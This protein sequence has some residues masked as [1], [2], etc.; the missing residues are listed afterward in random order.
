MSQVAKYLAR[1]RSFLRSSVMRA[2]RCQAQ[3]QERPDY[4]CWRLSEGLSL[5]I[6]IVVQGILG[7]GGC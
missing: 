4:L 5:Q 7:E 6:L 1:S 2:C 3:A